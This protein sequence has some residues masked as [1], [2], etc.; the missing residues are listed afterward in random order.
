MILEIN[1]FYNLQRKT[2]MKSLSVVDS[3]QRLFDVRKS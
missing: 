2:S 1:T 3:F